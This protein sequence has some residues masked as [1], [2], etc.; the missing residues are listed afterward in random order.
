MWSNEDLIKRYEQNPIMLPTT[1][2]WESELVYNT[3]ALKIKGITYLIYR[4]MGNDHIARFGLA[5][6]EDGINFERLNFPIMVPTESYEIP[7]EAALLRE[8][9]RG[10]LEDPRAM[11]IDDTIY[12]Y[13]T[14]FHKMCHI[15]KASIPVDQFSRLAEQSY[16]DLKKD[17]SEEWNNLWIR[18]GLVFPEKFKEKGT[19]SRNVVI[20]KINKELYM[21]LY[22]VN[23][24]NISV[25]FAK[26]PLGPWKDNEEELFEK[27]FSWEKERMGMSTPEIEVEVDGKLKK[28]FFYHGVE[29]N[30]DGL[31]RRYHLGGF[32]LEEIADGNN[33]KLNIEKINVPLL[34]PKL[35]YE[36]DGEWLNAANVNA[37]FSCGAVKNENEIYVYYGAGDETIC[38]GKIDIDDLLKEERTTI[39]KNFNLSKYL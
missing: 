27:H 21:M 38:V 1:N 16:N 25:S 26:T 3:A 34:S 35:P 18:N 13:Y 11:V 37:I 31:E 10:G 7:S 24:S 39:T 30:V 33:V 4:A 32:L 29:P 20:T 36:T 8:R 28:L 5:R 2:I 15:S 6:S 19:F 12:L 23:K 14:S 22:R 9:E 17:Y